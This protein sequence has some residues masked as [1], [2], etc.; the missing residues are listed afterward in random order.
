MTSLNDEWA[1]Y[2]RLALILQ[3]ITLTDEQR[4]AVTRQFELL[5]VMVDRFKS[6][7][8][9]ANAEPAPVFRL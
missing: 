1:D 6:E 2:V 3:G 4:A 7:P 9:P 8:M 5:A